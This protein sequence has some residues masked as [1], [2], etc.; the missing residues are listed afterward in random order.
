[1]PTTPRFKLPVS[2]EYAES[3]LAMA[4]AANVESRGHSVTT[5]GDFESCVRQVAAWATSGSPRHSLMLAG[6]YGNGK[7]TFL[8][9][10]QSLANAFDLKDPV[11]GRRMRLPLYSACALTEMHRTGITEWH[12]VARS[13]LLAIDDLGTEPREVMEFGNMVAPLRELLETRYELCLPTLIS[14]NMAP[15]EIT[16]RYGNRIGDRMREVMEVVRFRNDSYRR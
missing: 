11:T 6:R 15:S 3:C 12:K 4:V 16:Q 7:T 9:A 1:M 8:R 2:K 14:T 5:A 10:L 13:P